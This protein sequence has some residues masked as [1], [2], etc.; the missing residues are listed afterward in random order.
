MSL[1]KLLNIVNLCNEKHRSYLDLKFYS[2][3][4]ILKHT[5]FEIR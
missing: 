2:D 3:L 1:T 4:M 5:A